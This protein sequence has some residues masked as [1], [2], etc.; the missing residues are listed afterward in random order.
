MRETSEALTPKAK[1]ALSRAEL[2][3]AMRDRPA[4]RSKDPPSIP[5]LP[6]PGLA[7]P[8]IP[9]PGASFVSRWWR[10]H[11]ASPVLDLTQPILEHYATRNPVRLMALAA[12]AGCAMV[13]LRPWRLLS[14]GA[15][16]A[17]IFRGSALADAVSAAAR[18][19]GFSAFRATD[20]IAADSAADARREVSPALS[21][22]ATALSGPS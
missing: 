1:L 12:G 5:A 14:L 17:L 9:R 15:A 16:L 18:A 11:L 22:A 4:R 8:T 7:G 6:P 13:V 19:A 20:S 21:G 10:Q 3:A 2:L